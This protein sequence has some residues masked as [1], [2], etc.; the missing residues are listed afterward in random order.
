MISLGDIYLGV[1]ELGE[2][3]QMPF[4]V[5]PGLYGSHQLYL[6]H[7]SHNSRPMKQGLRRNALAP[8]FMGVMRLIRMIARI[9]TRPY[10]LAPSNF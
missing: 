3:R 8:Y 10:V 1:K 5:F 4:G 6:S 9:P 2:L 7:S